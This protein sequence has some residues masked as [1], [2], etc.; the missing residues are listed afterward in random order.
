ML[1]YKELSKKNV[2]GTKQIRRS[3]ETFNPEKQFLSSTR[4]NT[5]KLQGLQQ[6]F[7]EE[8]GLLRHFYIQEDTLTAQRQQ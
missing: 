7:M 5:R 1:K 4:Q 2:Y 6:V 3:T 8:A